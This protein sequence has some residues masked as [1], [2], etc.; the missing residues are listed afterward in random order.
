MN[1][2]GIAGIAVVG[3]VVQLALYV[4]FTGVVSLAVA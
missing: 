2:L 1:G 3:F 4:L